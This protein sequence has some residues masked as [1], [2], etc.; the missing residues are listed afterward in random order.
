MA[1]TDLSADTK[2]RKCLAVND[3]PHIIS[4]RLFVFCVPCFPLQKTRIEYSLNVTQVWLTDNENDNKSTLKFVRNQWIYLKSFGCSV[5][6]VSEVVDFPRCSTQIPDRVSRDALEYSHWT[7]LDSGAWKNNSKCTGECSRHVTYLD[8][9]RTLYFDIY[10][11][12][13]HKLDRLYVRFWAQADLLL[14]SAALLDSN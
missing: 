5:L 13:R 3:H 9:Y 14:I 1:C 10:V 11:R 12:C 2:K 4:C 7:K 8:K 6:N